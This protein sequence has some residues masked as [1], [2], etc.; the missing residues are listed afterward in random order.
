MYGVYA[1][2]MLRSPIILMRMLLL[3]LRLESQHFINEAFYPVIMYEL[4]GYK[5]DRHK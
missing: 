4:N 2:A 5:C 3:R 1:K